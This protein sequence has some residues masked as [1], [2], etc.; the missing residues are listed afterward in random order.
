VTEL[1]VADRGAVALR[2]DA[3]IDDTVPDGALRV[4]TRPAGASAE[5]GRD[6]DEQRYSAETAM[7]F[8]LPPLSGGWPA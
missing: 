5:C 6:A 4:G 2:L 1:Q 8:I 7:Y 3:C